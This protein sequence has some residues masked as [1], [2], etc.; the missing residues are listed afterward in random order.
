MTSLDSADYGI[1]PDEWLVSYAAG[2]LNVGQALMVAAHADYHPAL[3]R[4]VRQAEDI[5]GAMLD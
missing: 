3:Q 1:L 2:A 4:K 5:G